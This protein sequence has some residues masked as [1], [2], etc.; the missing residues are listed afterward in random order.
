MFSQRGGIGSNFVLEKSAWWQLNHP[1]IAVLI[2]SYLFQV[3][4][5][6]QDTHFLSE[7]VGTET[8]RE[9]NPAHPS[10]AESADAC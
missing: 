7:A 6:V 5:G 8:V 1:V 2:R 4:T 10:T 3:G 9:L